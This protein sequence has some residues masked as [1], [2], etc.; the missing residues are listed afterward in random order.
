MAAIL[1]LVEIIMAHRMTVEVDG[2]D[3][4][5]EYDLHQPRAQPDVGYYPAAR[6]EVHGKFEPVLLGDVVRQILA[7]HAGD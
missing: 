1:T 6:V 4:V 3:E 7:C 2:E 5:V